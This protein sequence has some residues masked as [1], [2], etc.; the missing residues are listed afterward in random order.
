MTRPRGLISLSSN[1]HYDTLRAKAWHF[2]IF[3]K[4]Y[5]IPHMA[6]ALIF[7]DQMLSVCFLNHVYECCPST[8]GEQQCP[9]DV[10]TSGLPARLRFLGLLPH[11]LWISGTAC[12]VSVGLA[13]NPAHRTV[14][15]TSC[16]EELISLLA[17]L[18]HL[19]RTFSPSSRSQR[20]HPESTLENRGAA[21]YITRGCR[22]ILEAEDGICRLYHAAIRAIPTCSFEIKHTF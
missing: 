8:S 22:R 17:A 7:Q 20:L 5:L 16:A 1:F 21:V 14:H 2:V 19:R 9:Y 6:H 15:C 11:L 3:V 18:P 13:Y 10:A 4:R 12:E